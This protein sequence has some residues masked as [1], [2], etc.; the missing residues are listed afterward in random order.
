MMA[1]VEKMK[2]TVNKSKASVAS[3]PVLSSAP[4][5]SARA[6]KTPPSQGGSM[7]KDLGERAPA[8]WEFVPASGLSKAA[9]FHWGIP[10]ESEDWAEWNSMNH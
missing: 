5:F 6:P 7:Q 2:K 4:G 1:Q 10:A 9:L 3:G 8:E